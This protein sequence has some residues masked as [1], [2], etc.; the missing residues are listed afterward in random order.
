MSRKLAEAWFEA[1][2]SKGITKLAL[3]LAEDFVHT[4]PFGEIKGRQGVSRF[5]QSKP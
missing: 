1:F 3:A 2:R 4:S 5:G